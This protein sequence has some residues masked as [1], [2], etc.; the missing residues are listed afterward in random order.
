MQQQLKPCQ[1]SGSLISFIDLPTKWVNN[2]S[3]GKT[4]DTQTCLNLYLLPMYAISAFFCYV[5]VAHTMHDISIDSTYMISS[6]SDANESVLSQAK[7]KTNTLSL[8]HSLN[9]N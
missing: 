2:E 4:A 3:S 6:L 5:H 7:L 8:I 9:I 1:E